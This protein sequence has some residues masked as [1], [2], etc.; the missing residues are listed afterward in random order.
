MN[1][2]DL[3]ILLKTENEDEHLE[4]KAAKNKNKEVI[5]KHLEHYG[6]G[7]MNEFLDALKDVQRRTVNIY[8]S[9]LKDEGKIELMGNPQISRGKN[10]AYWQLKKI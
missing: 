1:E 4:F 7:Y 5:L 6:K 10:K 9:E 8:L 3:Q 2:Q